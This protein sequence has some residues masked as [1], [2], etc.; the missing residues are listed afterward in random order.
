MLFWDLVVIR[1]GAGFGVGMVGYSGNGLLDNGLDE[2]MLPGSE[3]V[4]S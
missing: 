4:I 3:E 2:C 1:V